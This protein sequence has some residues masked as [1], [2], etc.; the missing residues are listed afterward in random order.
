MPPGIYAIHSL[1]ISCLSGHLGSGSSQTVG[2]VLSK[3]I[4]SPQFPLGYT[5]EFL[6]ADV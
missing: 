2:S 5:H 6:S 1:T 4:K 3:G